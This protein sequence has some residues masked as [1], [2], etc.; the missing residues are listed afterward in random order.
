MSEFK[1]NR[2]TSDGH[3]D[4]NIEFA[5]IVPNSDASRYS[6][7]KSYN[8]FKQFCYECLRKDESF[9]V[10]ILIDDKRCDRDTAI[11]WFV[12]ELEIA[13]F[14]YFDVL[15]WGIESELVH[16]LDDFYRCI[17]DAHRVRISRRVGRYLNAH[18][19]LGCMH[20]ISIWHL[21]RL[22]VISI[23]D[24]LALRIGRRFREL[25][26]DERRLFYAGRVVSILSEGDRKHEERA[27]KDILCHVEP[28]WDL[29]SYI[30]RE[31]YSVLE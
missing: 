20:D 4:V 2:A 1:L 16:Y 22:G 25:G 8:I 26:D 3:F 5:H 13:N 19:K 24:S 31:F 18:G 12:E 29:N 28:E 17:D 23:Q 7:T 11:R 14:E 10:S 6:F 9:S 27:I 15:Y 21:L 30:E